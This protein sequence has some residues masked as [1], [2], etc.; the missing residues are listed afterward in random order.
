MGA[1]LSAGLYVVATPI[2]NLGDMTSRAAKTLELADC[3]ACEDTRVTGSLLSLLGL[4][5]KALL[6]YHDHNEDRARPEIMA[7]L[8]AG[9]A[10]ALVSDAGTPLVSDPGYRLV[11]AV[12]E[13]GYGVFAVPGASALL[14]ALAVAGLP[15]D[16]FLF[17]GFL[18]VKD[19]ARTTALAEVARVPATLVFYESPRRLHDALPAM[20]AGLGDRH[21]AVCRELTKR[22]EEVQRGLLSELIAYYAGRP[23]PKGEVVIVIAPPGVAAATSESDIDTALRQALAGGVSLRDAAQVVAVATGRPRREVYARAL[24]L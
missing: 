4:K 21:A 12:A 7:R 5:A 22:H 10:V 8:A 2:G 15:T 3:V 1:A 17:A 20:L 19:G 11:K 9:Q 13:A 24:A 18:P 23:T 14:A 16:R 6:S